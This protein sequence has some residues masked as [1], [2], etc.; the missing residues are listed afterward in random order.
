LTNRYN[1]KM[2]VEKIAR[3]LVDRLYLKTME[4]F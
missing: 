4:R 3:R 1:E 2:A